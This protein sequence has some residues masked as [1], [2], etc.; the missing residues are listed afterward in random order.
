MSSLRPNWRR[1]ST[2]AEITSRDKVKLFNQHIRSSGE[3]EGLW[4]TLHVNLSITQFHSHLLTILSLVSSFKCAA[5]SP[6]TDRMWQQVGTDTAFELRT[7]IHLTVDSQRKINYE[8]KVNVVNNYPVSHSPDHAVPSIQDF[9]IGQFGWWSDHLG[10][11]QPGPSS[12]ICL[13]VWDQV[14]DEWRCKLVLFG[15]DGEGPA[16]ISAGDPEQNTISATAVRW[17]C[18]KQ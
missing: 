18:S 17:S 1:V 3:R 7:K 13:G 4:R 16:E 11:Q 12:V 9:A 15:P 5:M 14:G 10:E 8:L 2:E 6:I